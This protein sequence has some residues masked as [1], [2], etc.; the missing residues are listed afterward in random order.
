[1][2]SIIVPMFNAEKTIE[3][4]LNSI[5]FQECNIKVEIIVVNDGST[6]NSK[7]IVENYIISKSNIKLF[8]LNKNNGGAS[9]ARNEGLNFVKGDHILFLDSDDTFTTD[10]INYFMQIIS[11]NDFDIACFGYEFFDHNNKS[12]LSFKYNNID[13]KINYI[14]DFLKNG[15]VKNVIWNKIYKKNFLIDNNIKFHSN[16][17]PNEDSLFVFEILLKTKNIIFLDKIAYNHISDNINSYT[18]KF[19]KFQYINAI[20]LLSYYNKLITNNLDYSYYDSYKVFCTRILC[21]LMFI[22]TFSVLEKNILYESLD[23]IYN[24]EIWKELKNSKTL[25]FKYKMIVKVFNTRFIIW[26]LV[27]F[28]KIFNFRIQ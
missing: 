4:C 9:S 5:T 3:R 23:I 13:T 1:M 28:L 7:T 17:E 16:F 27:Q 21:R 19:Q 12:L 15:T 14:N 11:S 6:D 20:G 22:S 18:N 24:S 2:I 25:D 8:L 10:S 26:Y